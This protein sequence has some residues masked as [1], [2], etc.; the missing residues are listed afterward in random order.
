MRANAL[1]RVKAR[2]PTLRQRARHVPTTL[3]DVGDKGSSRRRRATPRG[4]RQ[5]GI[6]PSRDLRRRTVRLRPLLHRMLVALHLVIPTV[7]VA[8][9][10]IDA[11]SSDRAH[12]MERQ[13]ELLHAL[14]H[15]PRTNPLN[16]PPT[17]SHP[18]SPMPSRRP[19]TPTVRS[20]SPQSTP[21]SR[22]GPAPPT[23]PSSRRARRSI[24][25]RPSTSNASAR[26][27]RRA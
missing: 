23:S 11:V 26:G 4:L 19:P 10:E 20:A 16:L 15:D 24:A 7:R 25:G 3:D 5:R 18:S 8:A 17:I 14:A 2:G 6:V 12:Q 13:P 9:G 21:R 1:R 27:R 22:P